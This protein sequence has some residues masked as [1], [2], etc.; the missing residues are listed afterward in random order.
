MDATLKETI[1]GFRID[2]RGWVEIDAIKK[3]VEPPMEGFPQSFKYDVYLKN[4]GK[5]KA[6]NIILRK[7]TASG[8]L[9]FMSNA[10]GIQRTQ[11]DLLKPEPSDAAQIP[12]YPIPKVIAPNAVTP[13]PFTL[14]GAA[15]QYSNKYYRYPVGRI[16]YTDDFGIAHWIKFCFVVINATGDLRYCEYGNEEDS[17][18]ETP[19]NN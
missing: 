4:V 15:P 2:E 8:G 16:D 10:R 5:T 7:V 19:T 17:N 3:T 1:K 9:D 6:H 18:P 12:P 14:D 13:I 11:D